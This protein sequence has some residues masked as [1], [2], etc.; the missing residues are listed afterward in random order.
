MAAGV[1][2]EEFDHYVAV[3]NDVQIAVDKT[4]VEVCASVQAA[5]DPGESDELETDS[6]MEGGGQ[7]DENDGPL[8]HY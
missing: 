8:R 4:D 5:T 3:D 2:T 6:T 1:T 7:G